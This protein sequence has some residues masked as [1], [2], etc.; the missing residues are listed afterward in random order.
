MAEIF[1]LFFSCRYFDPRLPF[2]PD[3]AQYVVDGSCKVYL[4]SEN[5]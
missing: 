1:H 5:D 4:E 3:D 2:S